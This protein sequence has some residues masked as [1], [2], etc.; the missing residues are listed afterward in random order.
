MRDGD[1]PV[2]LTDNHRF[3]GAD[4]LQES[5]DNFTML[6]TQRKLTVERAGR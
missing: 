6:V 4:A 1:Q 5:V 3:D 2:N